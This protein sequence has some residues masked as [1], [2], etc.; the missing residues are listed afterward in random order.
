M[1]PLVFQ[2]AVRVARFMS[3]RYLWIDALCIIQDD[4]LDWDDQAAKMCAVYACAT[5]V[6]A[7][8]GARDPTCGL[9][10]GRSTMFDEE[11]FGAHVAVRLAKQGEATATPE[12][13][14][15]ISTNTSFPSQLD[16]RLIDDGGN[17]SGHGEEKDRAVNKD[18]ML[19][20][21]GWT[22]QE[23]VLA[24]RLLHFT[25]S[26]L[27]WECKRHGYA[28]EDGFSVYLRDQRPTFVEVKERLMTERWKLQ[29]TESK[30]EMVKKDERGGAEREGEKLMKPHLMEPSGDNVAVLNGWYFDLITL[31][32]STRNLTYQDDRLPAI[33]GLANLAAQ[34]LQCD[35]IAGMWRT[36]LEWA[37]TWRK[38]EAEKGTRRSTR[39][40]N[41][42]TP[43]IASA[44][45]VSAGVY[46]HAP[47]F[48]WAS[49]TGQIQWDYAVSTFVP[50]IRIDSCSVQLV[51]SSPFGRIH[52][53]FGSDT[54]LRVHGWV[55]KN[56]VLRRV[57]GTP[58]YTLPGG[59][60]CTLWMDHKYET[61]GTDDE[62]DGNLTVALL[63][64]GIGAGPP[65]CAGGGQ[66][67]L[68]QGMGRN[69][70]VLV[71]DE[72]ARAGEDGVF[73]RRGIAVF[74]WDL[75]AVR[76]FREGLRW[77]AATL[78]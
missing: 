16:N 50:S 22:L 44:T 62:E 68:D 8:D 7:A 74:D 31:R 77:E 11:P 45:V 18:T 3:I 72:L 51:G 19:V 21:R 57:P 36:G 34:T 35:Y 75:S 15:Y 43:D 23:A 26:Q 47:S 61:E 53:G 71:L 37:M 49:S 2:H 39:K 76:R 20:T 17:G 67:W 42:P 29:G 64:L 38:E 59:I 13:T 60:V 66:W 1:L 32:Y 33:A 58:A 78:V 9:F 48:S 55:A 30:S 40:P 4:P 28:S 56:A 5:L 54:W 73:M 12:L 24:P 41:A 52:A 25:S 6:L 46:H 14:I 69:V 10:N 70:C 65:E 27:I 63:E